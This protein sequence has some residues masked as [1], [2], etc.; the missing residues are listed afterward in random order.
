VEYISVSD[1]KKFHR[2]AIDAGSI[3]EVSLRDAVRDEGA[4][5][6]IAEGANGI[7]D[8]LERA[9]FLL[10]RIAVRHP[11]YEGNKRTA[12]LAAEDALT[13]FG[14]C[15]KESPELNQKVRDIASEVLEEGEIVPWLKTVVIPIH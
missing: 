1:R 11:F 5:F 9:A 12:L 6:F 10:H 8:P 14:Y 2:H 13:Q 3:D 15:I 7:T 4:L